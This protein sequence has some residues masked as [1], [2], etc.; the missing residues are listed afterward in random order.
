LLGALHPATALAA[1]ATAVLIFWKHR[2]N[3][4]RLREGRENRIA[5]TLGKPP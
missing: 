1:G 3:I 4:V 5:R 2:E